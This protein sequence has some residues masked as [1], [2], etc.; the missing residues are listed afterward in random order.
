LREVKSKSHTSTERD[1]MHVARPL[2]YFVRHHES[3]LFDLGIVGTRWP[4][5]FCAIG[6]STSEPTGPFEAR[7]LQRP[8]FLSLPN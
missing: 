5:L 1:L 4:I 7:V 3:E 8:A 2:N 6:F